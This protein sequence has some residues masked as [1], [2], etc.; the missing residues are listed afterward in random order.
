M[1]QN[2]WKVCFF[3]LA[4]LSLIGLLY[5]FMNDNQTNFES[6]QTLAAN[7]SAETINKIPICEIAGSVFV[8][9]EGNGSVKL[10][11]AYITLENRESGKSF[12]ATANADGE[13]KFDVPQGNYTVT[14]KA[15]RQYYTRINRTEI[16]NTSRIS[17]KLKETSRQYK[18]SILD[19]LL[20][21]GSNAVR[22]GIPDE[23]IPATKIVESYDWK[24]TIAV[25]QKLQSVILSNDNLTDF[26]IAK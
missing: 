3:T 22:S 6:I 16:L 20:L 2:F 5:L 12:R 26:R 25:D 4:I 15:M 14:A 24:F 21:T 23:K 9:T 17:S 7:H 19:A 10:G 13:F 18:L 1:N 11:L 8:L